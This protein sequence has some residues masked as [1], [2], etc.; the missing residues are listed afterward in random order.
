MINVS[1][2]RL[3]PDIKYNSYLCQMKEIAGIFLRLIVLVIGLYACDPVLDDP[4][5][6]RPKPLGKGIFILNYGLS[7]GDGASLNFFSIDS[8]RMSRNIFETRNGAEAGKGLCS[9]VKWKQFAFFTAEKSSA[10][11]VINASTAMVAGRYIRLNEPRKLIVIDA[12]KTYLSSSSQKGINVM[13]TV[14]LQNVGMIAIPAK[15][16]HLALA[17]GKVF[18]APQPTQ[19][20][21]SRKIYVVDYSVDMLVDSIQLSGQ[22]SWMETTPDGKLWV[23][24][25]GSEAGQSVLLSINS[26]TLE[27]LAQHIL[28]SFEYQQSSMAIVQSDKLAVLAGNVYLLNMATP[29]STPQLLINAADRQ[30]TSLLYDDAGDRMYI[31]SIRAGLAEGHLYQFNTSGILIDSVQTGIRPVALAFN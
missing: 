18:A 30:F 31:T 7:N 26:Q 16:E 11:W 17:S 22:V 3:K 1:I 27:L 25:S 21:A 12:E 14:S 28:P 5:P 4:L 10:V 23:L 19:S 29:G 13:H 24:C 8:N 20:A 6:D 9:I 15:I 2:L